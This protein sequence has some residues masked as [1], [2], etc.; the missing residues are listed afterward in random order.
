MAEIDARSAVKTALT[1]IGWLVVV[2]GCV[3]VFRAIN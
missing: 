3:A 2:V 1:I